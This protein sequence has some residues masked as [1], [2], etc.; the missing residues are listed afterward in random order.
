MYDDISKPPK[1]LPQPDLR[2]IAPGLNILP[3]LT[4]SG[5]AGP[6]VII[7]VPN[8]TPS[9]KI[10]QGVPS[11]ALKWAE[12][13]YAVAEIQ[14]SCFTAEE[15]SPLKQAI[16]ALE[17]CTECSSTEKVGLIGESPRSHRVNLTHD[18]LSL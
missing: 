5:Q 6:G 13:G 7:L 12:E 9:V 8:G 11:L 18:E 10:E 4:R 1:P 3:P 15:A 17:K 14:S 2:N 16:E